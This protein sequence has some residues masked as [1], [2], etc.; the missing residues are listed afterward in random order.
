MFRWRWCDNQ[1]TAVVEMFFFYSGSFYSW[2]RQRNHDILIVVD[3][4][5]GL[6]GVMSIHYTLMWQVDTC[7]E[8]GIKRFKTSRGSAGVSIYHIQ[9]VLDSLSRSQIK[10]YFNQNTQRY[11]PVTVCS[12]QGNA[13]DLLARLSR[14]KI[15]YIIHKDS[16]PINIRTHQA[17]L[18]R[19]RFMTSCCH[20]FFFACTYMPIYLN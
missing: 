13:A 10:A 11:H 1:S 7:D 5:L 18:R 14:C 4:Y 8:W 3:R 6:T 16:N 2:M 12:K 20:G 9:G 19:C 15:M 17:Q